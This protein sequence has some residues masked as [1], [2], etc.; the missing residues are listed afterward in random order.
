MSNKAKKAIRFNKNIQNVADEMNNLMMLL[1]DLKWLYFY[2]E[3]RPQLI[4]GKQIITWNDHVSDRANCGSSFTTLEQYEHILKTGAF[5]CILFDGSIIR[6]SITFD[7]KNLINHSHLWWPAPFIDD[8]NITEEFTPQNKYEDFLN[9]PNWMGKLRMR[10]PIRIDFDPENESESHPL[11]HMHTQHHES[12]VHLDSPIC[13]SKFVKYIFQSFYPDID[14]DF[15]KWNLL[16]FSYQKA[17]L[18]EYT[19]SSV[20][21]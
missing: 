10:S 12:R 21:I 6:S 2:K 4:N 9:D 5:H 3:V 17:K 8:G 13:F 20:I 16:S 15:R 7:S 1:Y 18:S 11:V 14:L 19:F